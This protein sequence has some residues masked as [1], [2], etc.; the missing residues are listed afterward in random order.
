MSIV[1]RSIAAAT[2]LM[3]AL[4]GQLAAKVDEPVTIST[5]Q[6]I[7]FNL[8]QRSTTLT[9]E[10]DDPKAAQFVVSA[11]Q[12]RDVTLSIDVSDAVAELAGSANGQT[13]KIE[14]TVEPS[15]CAYS[16]DGGETWTQFTSLVE[17]IRMPKA[18]QGESVSMVL[19]RVGCRLAIADDQQRGPYEGTI[20]L[21]GDYSPGND[22]DEQQGGRRGSARSSETGGPGVRSSERTIVTGGTVAV[23]RTRSAD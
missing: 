15:H 13:K 20:V 11:K 23:P 14:I 2:F 21:T 12:N 8:L 1:L 7:D 17:E 18:E 6:S 22:E 9:I 5:V 4:G 10:Y 16:V 3:V 19:V